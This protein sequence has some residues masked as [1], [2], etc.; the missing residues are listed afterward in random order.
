MGHDIEDF[1]FVVIGIIIG[2]HGLI[3]IE[4]E[5]S[6][7]IV[8]ITDVTFVLGNNFCHRWFKISDRIIIQNTAWLSHEHLFVLRLF[9]VI[10]AIRNRFRLNTRY[11][12]FRLLFR[13]SNISNW[14]LTTWLLAWNR[15]GCCGRLR[16]GFRWCLFRSTGKFRCSWSHG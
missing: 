11:T 3:Q 2:S 12:L 7:M 10:I 1:N 15:W 5:T 8:T 16:F 9:N 6:D 14:W 4:L 13:I